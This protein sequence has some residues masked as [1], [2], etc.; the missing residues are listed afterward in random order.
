MWIMFWK[1]QKSMSA[2]PEP[3]HVEDLAALESINEDTIMQHLEA[4]FHKNQYYTYVGDILLFL[5]PNKTL[6]IFGFQVS[7]ELRSL[8]STGIYDDICI[9]LTFPQIYMDSVIFTELQ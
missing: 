4:R 3:M 1:F 7:I 5:N 6:N 2:D 9:L 8:M